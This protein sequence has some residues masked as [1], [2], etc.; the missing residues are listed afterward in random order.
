MSFTTSEPG[1]DVACTYRLVRQSHWLSG[2]LLLSGTQR[3][4]PFP[5]SPFLSIGPNRK[6]EE[7]RRS[8]TGL[9]VLSYVTAVTEPHGHTVLY[10]LLYGQ[11]QP[12]PL[13]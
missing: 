12:Q 2:S 4:S 8:E 13:F 10:L 7:F 1:D 3:N 6:R 9:V 5:T 11:L